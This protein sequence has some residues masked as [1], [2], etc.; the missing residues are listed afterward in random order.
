M[1]SYFYIVYAFPIVYC[2]I[3]I[4]MVTFL[5]SAFHSWTN[6]LALLVHTSVQPER[7]KMMMMQKMMMTQK[8]R[9]MQKMRMADF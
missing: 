2:V 8:M 4:V 3:K 6:Y 5:N 1:L 9:M 7:M